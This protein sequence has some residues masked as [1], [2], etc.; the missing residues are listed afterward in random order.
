M[1]CA[2][3]GIYACHTGELEKTPDHCPMGEEDF[4]KETFKEY[5]A[6]E[7]TEK[8]AISAARVEGC[9]Y[10][11]WTRLEEIMEFAKR[12]GYQ[13]LGLAFCVG[14]KKEAMATAKI[15]ARGGFEIVSVACKTGSIPKEEIGLKDEEKVNPGTREPICNPIAQAELFNKANTHFNVIMGLCVGHDTLFI[16]H[17]K[18]P[19]TTFVTKDRVLAHNPLAAIYC[20]FYFGKRFK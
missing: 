12:A 18:A 7:E 16:Q 11:K 8:I 2:S 20:D 17:A 19:V 10:G 15:L 14:L 9:G 4:F 1:K 5:Q 6:N 3:C 13:K